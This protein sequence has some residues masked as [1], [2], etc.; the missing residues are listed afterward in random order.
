MSAAYLCCLAF[1]VI[2]STS[3][4]AATSAVQAISARTLSGQE[5]VSIG[6]IHDVQNHFPEALTYY[7]QAVD[8]FRAHKQRKGEATALTKIASILERQGRRKEAAA[9]PAASPEAVFQ[10]P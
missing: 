9:P 4:T 8:A 5:L 6:Q 2:V 7:E 3:V 1:P 10:M